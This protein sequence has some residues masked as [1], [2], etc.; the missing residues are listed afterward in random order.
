[1]RIGQSA[2]KSY[3]YLLGVFLGDGCVTNHNTGYPRF[4]LNT[5]DEDF[6]LATK[7]AIEDLV[8]N[9]V[10]ICCHPVS[11]S[12]KPNHALTCCSVELAKHLEEVTDHKMAI[13]SEVFQ[14][15]R[16]MKLEFISGLMDSEGWVAE[17]KRVESNRRFCMG[18]K[19]CDVWFDD[20]I[21]L[22]DELGIR[23]GKICEEKPR[24]SW[25][26]TPRKV[27]IKIQSFYDSGCAF[28]I[29]RKQERVEAF[30][31]QEPYVTRSRCPR[32]LT[33]ETIR[34]TA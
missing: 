1:M 12:S 24:K 7:K 4:R 18:F 15:S 23:H 21:S 14:W 33:S 32:R 22:L 27:S 20:F 16:E 8:E 2:G 11:K 34:S 3:A 6:A 9:P 25:Y 19:S 13:P 28:K 5:I 10:S 30:V 31:S 26:K 17:D 29:R